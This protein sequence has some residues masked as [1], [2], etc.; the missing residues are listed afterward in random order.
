MPIIMRETDLLIATTWSA[1]LIALDCMEKQEKL[2]GPA[3]R[4]L[5]YFIESFAPGA[6]PWSTQYA[7]AEQS[8]RHP[9]RTIPVFNSLTLKEFF[10][11]RGYFQTGLVLESPAPTAPVTRGGAKERIVLLHTC[12]LPFLDMLV[13][14]LRDAGGWE[15]WRFCAA[16]ARFNAASLSSDSGMESLGP[17]SP[18]A[19][20]AWASRAALGISITLSPA[21]NAPAQEMASAGV[22]TLCNKSAAPDQPACHENIFTF[23]T[24][25]IESA[26]ARLR[27]LQE[28]WSANPQ[29]GWAAIGKHPAKNA[30]I[31]NEIKPLAALLRAELSGPGKYTL[32]SQS[33]AS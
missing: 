21:P 9:A 28:I 24:F 30:A 14:S 25:T 27:E 22:L 26:A 23:E 7:L 31:S 13:R 2:Y 3:N 20:A 6:Y 32:P 4:K 12:C 1:A 10:T 19:Y 11:T 15:N 17:L 16:G 33:R 18:E 8:Y 5:V 29:A